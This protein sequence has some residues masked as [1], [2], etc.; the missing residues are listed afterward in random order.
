MGMR[1]NNIGKHSGED[2][3]GGQWDLTAFFQDFHSPHLVTFKQALHADIC[4]LLTDAA[5][6]PAPTPKNAAKWEALVLRAEDIG[7][8]TEHLS[9]YIDA[10]SACDAAN[11]AYGQ[12]KGDLNIVTAGI[13]K[14]K[15]LLGQALNSAD[16]GFL[17]PFLARDRL[18]E[19]S[20]ALDRLRQNASLRMDQE[21]EALAA[22][23]NIDGFHAWERLYHDLS[24]KLTFT[25][26]FPDG[27]RETRPMAQL[28]GLL[29]HPDHR[30]GRAAFEAGNRAWA[31]E[32][33][34]CA[35]ALNA[36]AGGRLT[37]QRYRG[38]DHFLSP[39]LFDAGIQKETLAAMYE[40]VYAHLNLASTVYRLKATYLQ[41]KGIW[42]FEREAALPLPSAGNITWTEALA[43][44]R[45]AF[46]SMYPELG[47][48]FSRMVDARWIESA[49]RPGKRPGAFCI[50][51]KLIRQQ[52]IYM[53][54][55]GTLADVQTLAHEAG[56]AWHGHLIGN[57]RPM[58]QRYPMPIA[59]T[60]SIFCE[61]ILTRS[62]LND[63]RL[64]PIEKLHVLNA[65]LCSAAVLLLDITCRFEFEKR[66]YE[67]RQEGVVPVSRLKEI[68]CSAQHRIYGDILLDNGADPL[69]WASKLHFYFTDVAFYNFPYTFGFL[70]AL[71]LH[72]RFEQ[73]GKAFL[74]RY[75][76][77]L[78][79]S[80]SASVE[81]MIQ[82]L[83]GVDIRRPE[84]WAEAIQSLSTQVDA[85]SELLK[86]SMRNHAA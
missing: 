32:A 23:L 56:H 30:I 54:F 51:S 21:K 69:F 25:M 45:N 52:R 60:A 53:S 63:P 50:H 55:S 82:A 58:A 46:E 6:M 83:F 64:D 20:Y 68:M 33:D 65:E 67:E 29:A 1:S 5:D 9:A 22:D 18:R 26:T 42:F 39:A 19:I 81:T 2:A 62:L 74:S 76:L 17:G 31:R 36:I 84:F 7:M 3:G 11:E 40:A 75:E 48:Y 38:I 27:H 14:F 57:L 16:P 12:A 13:E 44:V 59:E 49:L 37:L 78:K 47:D 34:S 35:A 15:V 73:E 28:R 85:Y 77:F 86:K 71:A 79:E 8:R 4:A 80:G 66:F 43:M 24:G 41:R 70:L 61:R 72:R 10:L